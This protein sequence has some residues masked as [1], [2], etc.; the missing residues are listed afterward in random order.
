MKRLNRTESPIFVL[1]VCSLFPKATF[2]IFY[3][4]PVN[5]YHPKYANTYHTSLKGSWY[6]FKGDN[7]VRMFL[8]PFVKGS[9]L[10]GKNLLP[11][12]ANSSFL[13]ETPLSDKDCTGKQTVNLKGCLPF[14]ANYF[15]FEKIP[16]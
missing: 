5:R 8:L 7:S 1:F 9:A 14:G 15:L 2:D 11:S 4:S 3:L 13:E 16:F 6:T 12:G 10:K